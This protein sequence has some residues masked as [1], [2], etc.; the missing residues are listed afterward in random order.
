MNYTTCPH[1]NSAKISRIEK[2][3]RQRTKAD[4]KRLAKD[5]GII[6]LCLIF[7]IGFINVGWWIATIVSIIFMVG[8]IK[9]IEAR[10]NKLDKSTTAVW[11]CQDCGYNFEIETT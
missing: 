2:K 4:K 9:Y 5:L 7:F 1:C 10:E 11:H 8:Y 6:F 3:K